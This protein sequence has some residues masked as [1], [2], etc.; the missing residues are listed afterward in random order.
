MGLKFK[1]HL[2]FSLALHKTR[3]KSTFSLQFYEVLIY[4]ASVTAEQMLANKIWL[5]TC[6]SVLLV[7]FDRL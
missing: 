4:F 7:G 5:V 1:V 3:E 6:M 2:A